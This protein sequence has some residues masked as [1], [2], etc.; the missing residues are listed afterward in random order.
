MNVKEYLSQFEDDQEVMIRDGFNGGGHL[1]VI[2]SH[3][4]SIL[5]KDDEDLFDEEG[6]MIQSKGMKVVE[7]AFGNY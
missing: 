7:L 4:E 6:E 3:C 5:D 2:N 1:R